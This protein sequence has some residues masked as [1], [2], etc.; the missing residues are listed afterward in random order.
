MPTPIKLQTYRFTETGVGCA[1]HNLPDC[2][3]DVH[4]GTPTEIIVGP[5]LFHNEALEYV[6]GYMVDARN[7]YDYMAARLGFFDGYSRL[8]ECVQCGQEFLRN[9][10]THRTCSDACRMKKSRESRVGRNV[11]DKKEF[12]NG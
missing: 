3:C 9:H 5:H 8:S 10:S 6:D 11:S 1:T 4:V 12:T 2:L 7:V